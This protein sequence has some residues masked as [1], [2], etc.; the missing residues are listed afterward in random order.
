VSPFATWSS[1]ESEDFVVTLTAFI[2]RCLKGG[3]G[4][5][6]FA[7]GLLDR[8]AG[9]ERYHLCKRFCLGLNVAGNGAKNA[10]TAVR[11]QCCGLR[12]ALI[13]GGNGLG[14]VL[15]TSATHTAHWALVVRAVNG[16]V[17][18]VGGHACQ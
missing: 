14:E 1:V 17:L 12:K 11:R 4:P 8:F 18:P 5:L 3:H 15:C 16:V 2:G 7:T 6:H 9:F 13:G 10:G